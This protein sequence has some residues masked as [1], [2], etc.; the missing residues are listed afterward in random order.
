MPY[1]N[2]TE[3]YVSY[4]DGAAGN[5]VLSYYQGTDQYIYSTTLNASYQVSP[6][7]NAVGQAPVDTCFL[8][9]GGVSVTPLLPALVNYTYM[10]TA[11]VILTNG[12]TIM[13][14]WW[15]TQ[16]QS[17]TRVNTYD[18]F[19]TKSSNTP[20]RFHMLGYDILLGSHYDEYLVDY[21]TYTTGPSSIPS[22]AFNPPAMNCEGVEEERGEELKTQGNGLISSLIPSSE[23]A[24]EPVDASAD[25]A[26]AAFMEQYG[27]SY[28]DPKELAL[29]HSRFLRSTR[30]IDVHNRKARA[31]AR[32]L[33]LAMNFL[34]DA[35]A[36]EMNLRR[37][38]REDGSKGKSGLPNNAPKVH[39]PPTDE[40]FA[41]LPPSI[42]WRD[43]GAVEPVVDQGICGSCWSHGATATIAGSYFLKYGTLSIFSKQ[44][45]VDCS[46]PMGNAGCN[47]GDDFLAYIWIMQNGGLATREQYGPYLM[48]NGWCGANH[49]GVTAKIASYV[50][51]T[52]GSE[53]ALMTA[54][55]N[56]GPV[57]AN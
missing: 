1:M 28:S 11:P 10:G 32:S 19:L 15:E 44:E 49:T 31:Q 43:K 42:D 33:R 4:F 53:T 12:S 40:E 34:G 5:Q 57:S 3:Q 25:P 47:G 45:L 38:K 52:S 17:L 35:T 39:L 56:I 14:Y 13:T 50:N 30:L 41:A 37:G 22:G 8:T 16:V 54:L 6:V 55:V 24:Y 7:V 23:E 29:R 51:V 9:P 18:L 21:L 26:Y 27:K 46:W 36:A 2:I 48:Q 20:L